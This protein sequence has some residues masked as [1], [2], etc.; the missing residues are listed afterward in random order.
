MHSQSE[1]VASLVASALLLMITPPL[2]LPLV[3]AAT[4][5]AGAAGYVLG[6]RQASSRT[7]ASSSSPA[8]HTKAGSKGTPK[9]VLPS[10]PEVAATSETPSEGSLDTDSDAEDEQANVRSGMLGTVRAKTMEECKL[11]LVV[12]QELGMSKGK[13]AAQCASASG[14]LPGRLL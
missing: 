11:V 1:S 8:P 5:A 10:T 2:A 4:L 12:N 13:I 14:S 3:F 7:S 9:A 6:A